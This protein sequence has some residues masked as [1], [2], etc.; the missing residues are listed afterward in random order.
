MQV[1]T[2]GA[3]P[4]YSNIPK[5]GQMLVKA[6]DKRGLNGQEASELIG[7]GRDYM[8]RLIHG[9]R[10]PSLDVAIRIEREFGIPVDSYTKGE[11]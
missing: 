8:S 6:M 11:R 9:K 5:A 4:D 1:K 10:K 7:I 3:P 2:L